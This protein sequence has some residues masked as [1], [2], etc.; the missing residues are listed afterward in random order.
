MI[1][2]VL[3]HSIQSLCDWNRTPAQVGFRTDAAAKQNRGS[4]VRTSGQDHQV[5]SQSLA[6]AI[7]N[8]VH[9]RDARASHM[10][11]VDKAI[12]NDLKIAATTGRVEVGK[13][14]IPANRSHRIDR[15]A[16]D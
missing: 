3:A 13:R 2:Q 4:P 6:L 1:D 12:R 5:G 15:P 7:A 9:A 8:Y 16:R 11:L 10:Q 14:G